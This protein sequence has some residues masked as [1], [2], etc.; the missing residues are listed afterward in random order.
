L[1]RST[2]TS[3][4]WLI[5]GSVGFRKLNSTYLCDTPS[6]YLM[7]IESNFPVIQN[8]KSKIQNRLLAYLQLMRPANIVTAW[9]DIMAGFAVTGIFDL[10]ALPWLLLATTGL[11]GGGIV[12]NDVFDAEIDAKERPER[13]IPSDRASH[14][15]AIVLGSCLLVMGIVAA[16][17]VSQVS[18]LI[19]GF[20][21]LAALIYDAF[22][23][24]N[25]VTGS[26]N[27][28][29]CRGGNFLLGMSAGWEI[30]SDRWYLAAIHLTYIVAVTA[31]SQGEIHGGDRKTGILALILLGSVSI[32]VLSL[33]RFDDFTLLAALPFYGLFLWRVLPTWIQATRF[34]QAE[35]IRTAVKA[36]VICLIVLDAAIAAGFAGIFNGLL[37][38]CLLPISILLAKPFAVT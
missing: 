25:P 24:H 27:M 17:L 19:A 26:L 34:P 1:R 13:P 29:L 32:A 36:G 4:H 12:F 6:K 2:A 15:G 21:A 35:S 3:V 23:K 38:L 5:G 10:K 30:L 14:S 22:G 28:G 7:Q 37:V 33:T 18:G 9:A 8:L 16:A 31:I 20:I 11:Y